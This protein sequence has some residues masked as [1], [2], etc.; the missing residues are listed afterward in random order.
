[1]WLSRAFNHALAVADRARAVNLFAAITAQ[2]VTDVQVADLSIVGPDARSSKWWDYTFSGIHLVECKRVR[3]ANVSVLHWPSDGI[4]VQRG[5]DVQ[6]THCQVHDCRGHGF[7]PGS[8]LGESIWSGNIGKNNGGDGFYFCARVHH[9]V[10]SENVFTGN[11][12]SGIG[13]VGSGGDHHN[14]IAA[15]V[16]GHNQQWGINAYEGNEHVITGNICLSNSRKKRGAFGGIRLHDVRHTLVQA[17]RCGD[18]QKRP[19]QTRGI[20][21]TGDS[22]HNLISANLC[23]GMKQPVAVT[24]R[25]S[26][27][28]ANLV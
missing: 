10:C 26:L 27:A 24:G 4:S 9:C 8:G 3:I 7:H 13:G 18:D 21:E 22:D 16:C 5:S 20:A 1:M 23:T 15:N 25:H 28:E 6:V 2:R 17:N 19:T 12:Q 14:V 11:G